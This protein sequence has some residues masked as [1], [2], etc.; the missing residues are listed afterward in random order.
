LRNVMASPVIVDLRNIYEPEGVRQ[1]G[2]AYVCV[3]R[4]DKGSL[5][6]ETSS[7]V[8]TLSHRKSQRR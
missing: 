5:N 8:A 1:H 2:F 7:E 3:G 4:V 6:S